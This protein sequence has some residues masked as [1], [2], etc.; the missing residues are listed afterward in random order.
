MLISTHSTNIAAPNMSVDS[1]P[2]ST[3]SSISSP[4]SPSGENNILDGIKNSSKPTTPSIDK[5]SLKRS[6]SRDFDRHI[7]I[8]PSNAVS[9]TNPSTTTINT[10]AME[11]EKAFTNFIAQTS[12]ASFANNSFGYHNLPPFFAAMQQNPLL[13]SQFMK[14]NH[15][16]ASA[17]SSGSHQNSPDLIEN[18]DDFED[19]EGVEPE[20]LSLLRAKKPE[21]EDGPNGPQAWSYEEQFQ[22]L[23][24]LS[25]S[26]DRKEWLDEWL[27]YMQKIGK[28]VT[29]VPIMA[30]MTLDLYELYRLVV[31]HGGLVEI[32]N[33]KLWRE[34]TKGL[35]LPSSITSAAF[36]LRTQ[37]QKY[38]YEFECEKEGL[39]RPEDLQQAI[40][41]NR[42][43]G[44]R[45][46]SSL[47]G[48]SFPY[49]LET[50]PGAFFSKNF[51]GAFG[52]K[53]DEDSGLAITPSHH[54]LAAAFKVEQMAN[55]EAH[56]Q[57][58]MMQRAAHEAISRQQAVNAACQMNMQQPAPSQNQKN[59][60]DTNR[61]RDSTS[62]VDSNENGPAPKKERRESVS[63]ETSVVK[64][65]STN[66]VTP[67]AHFKIN[68][69]KSTNENSMVVSMELNGKMYQGVLFAQSG[70]APPTNGNNLNNVPTNMNSHYNLLKNSLSLAHQGN[71]LGDCPPN[72][73]NSSSSLLFPT[74]LANFVS[75]LPALPI[76]GLSSSGN[77]SF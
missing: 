35:N 44:R 25:D 51:N 67:S 30:K 14:L 50:N 26:S 9:T 54:A 64:S 33:K 38:L 21:G 73:P 1:K 3:S 60:G 43:E 16:N 63:E 41:G 34:I 32:I 23:Y 69:M 70:N 6:A 52:F 62:S 8:S 36:T 74:D 4:R 27:G 66:N 12:G 2:H 22:P 53:T 39:S 61:D 48:S 20:D 28:P 15:F 59:N 13:Q 56:R 10:A 18:D 7:S 57:F 47:P 68:S 45:N 75:T 37:Y 46:P 58:E 5:K 24:N 42:R 77:S 72:H 11:A 17:T 40:D 19:L 55:Y 65:S 29:R 71:S 76:T 31:H 49:Q